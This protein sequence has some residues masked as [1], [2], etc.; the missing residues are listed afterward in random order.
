MRLKRRTEICLRPVTI[1]V[2][3]TD[4]L[5]LKPFC[6]GSIELIACGRSTGS[7]VGQHGSGVMRPLKIIP[8][9]IRI[10]LKKK[11]STSVGRTLLRSAALQSNVRASPGLASATREPA[12]ASGPQVRAGFCA[13]LLG[14]CVLTCR[15]ILGAVLPLGMLPLNAFPLIVT[16]LKNP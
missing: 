4:L 5:D 6:V 14:F 2:L 12:V 11:K 10:D 13:P 16:V 15:M 3:S 7:H 9:I 1:S 8:T